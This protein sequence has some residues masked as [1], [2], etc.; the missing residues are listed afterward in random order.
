MARA[1]K[2]VLLLLASLLPAHALAQTLLRISTPAVPDDW[3]V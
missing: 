1:A 3:H 2:L